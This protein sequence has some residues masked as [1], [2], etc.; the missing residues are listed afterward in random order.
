MKRARIS[1]SG[2]VQG[3]SYRAFACKHARE[4]RLKGFVRNL[5]D[6]RV[7]VLAEGDEKGIQ[8]LIRKLK[9]GPSAATVENMEI[10]WEPYEGVY[11][12]FEIMRL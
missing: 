10:S 2:L 7:E 3:V 8:A 4:L 11:D 1:V 5:A 12:S 9:Q 6:G